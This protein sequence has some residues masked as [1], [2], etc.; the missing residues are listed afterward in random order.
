MIVQTTYPPTNIV[1]NDILKSISG[2]CYTYVGN[3]VN[4]I[5]PSGFI[6]ANADLFTAT[7]ATTYS[8]CINC[9]KTEV[10]KLPYVKWDAK[11]E[12]SVSCPV[13]EL[14]DFGGNIT[15]Y[16]SSADTSIQ[17]G[18]YIYENT[19]LTTPVSVTYVKYN[20]KIYDVS[21]DGEINEFCTVND[22]C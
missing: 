20:N 15:F 2:G 18:V 21:D 16:T 5:P 10:V 19:G 14:T 1:E 6:I 17:S 11:G 8:S 3:Y 9:L 12:Y 7:T 22:N 13:C 4:Y